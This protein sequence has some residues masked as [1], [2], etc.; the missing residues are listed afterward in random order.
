MTCNEM[1]DCPVLSA[2]RA[3]ELTDEQCMERAA[4]GDVAAYGVLFDRHQPRLVAFLM[5]FL[6]DRALAEDIAQEAFWNVWQKRAVF[7][8]HQSFRVFLYV[9]AK[10]LALNETASAQRRR[11]VSLNAVKE[12]AGPNDAEE[13]SAR[14]Q[15]Q[16][17]V[18]KALGELPA[19][20]RL[21]VLL[22]EYDGCTY[23]ETARILGCSEVHAR[24][25]AFR[26]RARLK[27]LLEPLLASEE[28]RKHDENS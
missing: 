10:N 25:L 14:R 18:R 17:I 19:D 20:Q 13:W 23:R 24:V 3:L 5:R 26:A 22:R 1:A 8:P 9:A 4:R 21:C 6:G 2:R 11:T 27:R 12:R 7:D 28:N 15:L 16:C